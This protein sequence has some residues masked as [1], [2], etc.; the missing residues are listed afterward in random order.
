[1]VAPSRH[2]F[3]LPSSMRKWILIVSAFFI[4]STM[5]AQEPSFRVI[6][7][8]SDRYNRN[9]FGVT[10]DLGINF[11]HQSMNNFDFRMFD[12]QGRNYDFSSEGKDILMV[13]P[14]LRLGFRMKDVLEL[15]FRGS[16]Y[17]GEVS[18]GGAYIR[19]YIETGGSD[20]FW[21]FLGTSLDYH[22]P[23][24]KVVEDIY[25]ADISVPGN[26]NV[27]LGSEH[28]AQGFSAGILYRLREVGFGLEYSYGWNIHTTYEARLLF[29][30]DDPEIQG[31]FADSHADVQLSR[32]GESL[33]N[34]QFSRIT[35]SMMLFF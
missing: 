23:Y 4:T 11:V 29:R 30:S 8:N 7:E 17:R 33:F 24:K 21:L 25:V 5:L 32:Y 14:E 13:G 12:N 2:F 19:W 20:K 15:G 26:Y 10:M 31:S 27:Y 16:L 9:P 18:N 28:F 22:R 34:S 6:T 3:S 1:M 35:L